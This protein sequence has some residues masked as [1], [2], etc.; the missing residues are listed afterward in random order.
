MPATLRVVV[1]R[2]IF[3]TVAPSRHPNGDLR[4]REYRTPVE[5]ERAHEA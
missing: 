5:V 2:T 4:A 1:P 3:R